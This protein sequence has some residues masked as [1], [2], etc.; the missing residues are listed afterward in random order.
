[1]WVCITIIFLV[2]AVVV[3]MQILSPH[4]AQMLDESHPAL[5]GIADAPVHASKLEVV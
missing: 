4:R 5:N 2:P 3:T 1:M